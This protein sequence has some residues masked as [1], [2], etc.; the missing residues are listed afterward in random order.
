MQQLRVHGPQ[1]TASSRTV[2]RWACSENAAPSRAVWWDGAAESSASPT[3]D[4]AWS[5]ETRQL[6]TP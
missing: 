6:I 3:K 5:E 1:N 2:G 4:A